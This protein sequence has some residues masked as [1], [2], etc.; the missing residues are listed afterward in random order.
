LEFLKAK[1]QLPDDRIRKYKIK[2]I[3]SDYKLYW[4]RTKGDA[5][6]DLIIKGK[7]EE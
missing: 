6:V 3:S 1:Q 5:E 2:K 4:W 7:N